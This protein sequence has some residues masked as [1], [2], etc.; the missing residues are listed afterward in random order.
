MTCIPPLA[1]SVLPVIVKPACE[2]SSVGI[3]A[4]SNDA[5]LDTPVA[6]AARYPGELLVEQ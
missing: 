3:T 5:D 2:G 6:L 4:C 1:A